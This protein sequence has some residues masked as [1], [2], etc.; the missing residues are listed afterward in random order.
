MP[1]SLVES[2]LFGHE[3]GA[4]TGADARRAGLCEVANRGTLFLDEIGEME[5][6][7]QS[8]LLRFL[9]DKSYRRVGSTKDRV[10]D[11]RIV[12]ATNRDSSTLVGDGV[13][14]E[15]LYYRLNVVPITIPPLRKRRSDIRLL[16]ERFI[17]D[18][19]AR[20]QKGP[21]NLTKRA[22]DALTEYDWPGNVRELKN[23]IER[24]VILARQFLIDI[25]Q[26]PTEVRG[27]TSVKSPVGSK[28]SFLWKDDQ[29]LT[30]MEQLQNQALL[31]ALSEAGGNVGRAAEMLGIGQATAYRRI[32]RYG[33]PL[34]ESRENS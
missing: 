15:D 8:K 32:K 11:T 12:S 3:R 1:S 13:F 25:Q 26:L 30:P 5:Y 34:G 17:A 27:D 4:F 23:V 6:D 16:V 29:T 31:Q 24:I 9:Q 22:L 33:I 20:Y 21:F 14:R 2:T 10:S 7:A 19:A 18:A 28:R